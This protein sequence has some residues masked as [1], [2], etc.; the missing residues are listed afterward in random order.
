MRARSIIPLV[1]AA[2][3]SITQFAIAVLKVRARD[4]SKS[5]FFVFFIPFFPASDPKL[6]R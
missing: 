5:D 2:D 4:S 6:P 3:A 1:R